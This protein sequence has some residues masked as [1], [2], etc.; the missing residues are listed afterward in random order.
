MLE[1]LTA[2]TES[3]KQRAVDNNNHLKTFC[4]DFLSDSCA[5]VQDV[6]AIEIPFFCRR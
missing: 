3:R 1:Y 6:I 4:I 5:P 2:S